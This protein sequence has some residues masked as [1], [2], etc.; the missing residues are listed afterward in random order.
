MEGG[1]LAEVYLGEKKL[2][3]LPLENRQVFLH[4][5]E[6]PTEFIWNNETMESPNLMKC[7]YHDV[8]LFLLSNSFNMQDFSLPL[9]FTFEVGLLVFEKDIS[10][11]IE[12]KKQIIYALENHKKQM[13]IGELE[14]LV[15]KSIV[16]LHQMAISNQMVPKEIEIEGFIDHGSVESGYKNS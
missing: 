8:G 10:E 2:E 11:T 3:E 12:G 4:S 16:V 5:N 1:W 14:E 9:S 6:Y 15:N 7:D 13:A